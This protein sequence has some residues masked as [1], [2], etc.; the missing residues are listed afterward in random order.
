M[1]FYVHVPMWF[2]KLGTQH[3]LLLYCPTLT[4]PASESAL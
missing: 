4:D 3:Y 2:K 1:C